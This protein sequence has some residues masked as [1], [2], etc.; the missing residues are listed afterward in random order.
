[1]YGSE[2]FGKSPRLDPTK[3]EGRAKEVRSGQ[4]RSAIADALGVCKFYA[5]GLSLT[6]DMVP[7][8]NAATGFDYSQEEF[9]QIGERIN[10]LT[11]IFNVR[12]GFGAG[13]DALPARCRTPLAEGRR[14]GMPLELGAM[15]A[16]YYREC[17]WD[18]NGVPTEEKIR[19]LGLEMVPRRNGA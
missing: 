17:G 18:Q 6:R 4:E 14:A 2:H 1:M 11:R 9:L 8:V 5:Y 12:E 16:E 13:D 15:L 10:N 3:D 19:S 7:L